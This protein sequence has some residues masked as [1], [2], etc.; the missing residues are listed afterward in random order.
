[1]LILDRRVSISF[2]T[3]FSKWGYLLSTN[4]LPKNKLELV[5]LITDGLKRCKHS[6]GKTVTCNA[7]TLDEKVFRICQGCLV[8]VF[9]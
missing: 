6:Q 2:Q 8:E 3:K 4:L 7:K 9:L 5:S 1:M